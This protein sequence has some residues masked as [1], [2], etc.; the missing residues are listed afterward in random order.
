MVSRAYRTVRNS[1]L[2][3]FGVLILPAESWGE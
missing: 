1:T 2:V 3:R